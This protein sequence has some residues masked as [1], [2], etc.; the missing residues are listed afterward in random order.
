MKEE[1]GD[2]EMRRD[3]EAGDGI[4]VE[5]WID[6]VVTL[7]MARDTTR[8]RIQLRKKLYL[9]VARDLSKSI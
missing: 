5:G 3:G 4:E 8:T 6:L 2:W 9:W 7:V 1:R